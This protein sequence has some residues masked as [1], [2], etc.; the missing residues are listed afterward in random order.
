MLGYQTPIFFSKFERVV[1]SDNL[2]EINSVLIEGS[3]LIIDALLNSEEYG[4]YT[5]QAKTFIAKNKDKYNLADD[6]DVDRLTEDLKR[7]L[8]HG[9]PELTEN[10]P[11]AVWF[12]AALAVVV[13]VVAWDGAVIINVVAVVNAAVY[14]L[15]VFWGPEVRSSQSQTGLDNDR[16]VVAIAENY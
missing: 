4:S 13:A 15:A 9:N 12:A 3:K 2:Y 1:K 5:E 8:Y 10:S 16:I 11:N 7:N 6:E 14:A